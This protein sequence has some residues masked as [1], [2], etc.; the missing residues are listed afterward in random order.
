[1]NLLTN[2]FVSF[3]EVTYS[4]LARIVGFHCKRNIIFIYVYILFPVRKAYHKLSLLVHPDRV[5]EKKKAEATEKFKVLGRIHSILSDNEKR[6]IYDESGKYLKHYRLHKIPAC[7]A[8]AVFSSMCIYIFQAILMK[9]VMKWWK[10]IGMNTGGG[11][12]NRSL[13]KIFL[14]MRRSIKVLQKGLSWVKKKLPY[15]K[16]AYVGLE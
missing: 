10:G 3:T 8:I 12:S 14:I 13:W 15:S 11:Y 2:L 16:A 9:R 6:A 5:E 7:I 1:M 4:Y